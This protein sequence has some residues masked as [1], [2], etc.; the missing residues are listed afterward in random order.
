L[1]YIYLPARSTEEHAQARQDTLQDLACLLR[2]IRGCWVV[3]GDFN[4]HPEELAA[5]RFLTFVQGT[6][7]ATKE[8]T[9]RQGGGSVIDYALIQANLAPAVSIERDLDSPWGP[10]YGIRVRI[11]VPKL[12]DPVHTWS[13][14]RPFLDAEGE[15][16]QEPE[17]SWTAG[18]HIWAAKFGQ[19]WNRTRHQV[20]APVDPH[21]CSEA[22]TTAYADFSAR[23]EVHLLSI[24]GMLDYTK[25]HSVGRGR[26][27]FHRVTAVAKRTP[28]VE[29][30]YEK[31]ANSLAK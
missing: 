1:Q 3:V 24:T 20:E 28:D 11:D 18:K 22:L 4:Q 30:Y 27:R 17:F 29:R 6:A 5:S 9:C 25:W 2:H 12:D 19:P 26:P 14:A 15:H 8:A 13:E 10:H 21:S 16:C 7:V 31:T 23:A